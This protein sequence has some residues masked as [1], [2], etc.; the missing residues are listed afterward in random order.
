MWIE[1]GRFLGIFRGVGRDG[2]RDKSGMAIPTK[3]VTNYEKLIPFFGFFYSYSE[4]RGPI[5]TNR[6]GLIE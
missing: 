4:P 3:M 1:H 2:V 6:T 5:M